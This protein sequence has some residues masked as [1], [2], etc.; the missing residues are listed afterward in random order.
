MARLAGW[1]VGRL[2]MARA[3]M[4]DPK[5]GLFSKHKETIYLRDLDLF[6]GA[7]CSS[8]QR[9]HASAQTA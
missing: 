7:A 1:L 3:V 2:L 4:Y 8:L 9:V 5:H 6:K